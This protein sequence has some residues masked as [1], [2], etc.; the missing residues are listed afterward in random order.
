MVS[1]KFRQNTFFRPSDQLLTTGL[2]QQIV[3]V[4]DKAHVAVEPS[5]YM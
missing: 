5:Q 3:V 2:R 1:I 4:S